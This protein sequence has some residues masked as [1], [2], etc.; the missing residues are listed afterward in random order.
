MDS[1]VW[2]LQKTSLSGRRLEPTEPLLL[3]LEKS[4]FSAEMQKPTRQAP[5][6]SQEFSTVSGEVLKSD[7]L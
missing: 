7:G 1:L 2:V 3:S 5:P 4:S 6:D